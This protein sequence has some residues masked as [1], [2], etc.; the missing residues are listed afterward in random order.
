MTLQWTATGT[1]ASGHY[2][3]GTTVTHEIE[4]R[5]EANGKGSLV[6]TDDGAQIVYDWSF[7][8]GPIDIDLPHGAK[9]TLLHNTGKWIGTLKRA[10]ANQKGT[11]IWL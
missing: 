5:A 2:Q 3:P 1:F 9:A 4:G 8:S 10:A 7:Y 11:Q 6:R